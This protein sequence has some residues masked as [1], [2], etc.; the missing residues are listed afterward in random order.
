MHTIDAPIARA[1]GG[2]RPLAAAPG[3][4]NHLLT[5]VM[6]GRIKSVD[7]LTVNQVIEHQMVLPIGGGLQVIHA[8]GH[9]AGQIALLWQ[10]RGV[11]FAADTCMN[12]RGPR[13][14][15]AYEDFDQGRIDLQRMAKLQFDVACFGHGDPILENASSVFRQRFGQS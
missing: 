7:P 10:N 3:V 1:G 9:C 5:F 11:L 15:I 4:L 2:F 8:P 6:V 12:L 14:S 13:W